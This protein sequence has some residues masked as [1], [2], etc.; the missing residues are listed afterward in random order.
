MNSSAAWDEVAGAA[1]IFGT[2]AD[3]LRALQLRWHTRLSGRIDAVLA[4]EPMDLEAAVVHAWRR[5]AADLPG[6]R[7]ILDASIDHPA[8]HAGRR[9][10]Q[11]LLAA[12]AGRATPGDPRAVPIGATI[13]ER[14]RGIKVETSMR[15]AAVSGLRRSRELLS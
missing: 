6:A 11:G 1:D 7:A 12:A 4:D 10:D 3:L 2:T 8:I 13:E 5:A 14:A 9:A 15:A